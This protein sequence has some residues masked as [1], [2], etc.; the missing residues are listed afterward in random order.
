MRG[1]IQTTL[2]GVLQ[3]NAGNRLTLDDFIEKTNLETRQIQAGI[4]TIIREGKWP[5]APIIRG[6]VWHIGRN[7]NPALNP[8]PAKE[9][10][11]TE[12]EY[13]EL[14]RKHH[15]NGGR[16]PTPEERVRDYLPTA[17]VRDETERE[18]AARYADEQLLASNRAPHVVPQRP[19]PT[20]QRPT[21]LATQATET[22][23][24]Y[25]W[26][27]NRPDGTVLLRDDLGQW[28]VYKEIEKL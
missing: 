22:D 1:D 15:D 13:T 19:T 12:A 3:A 9:P 21:H 10:P 20:P 16:T 6:R 26:M 25:E 17:V 11:Y 28:H 14:A 8:A 24:V 4:S 2:Y 5:I 27:G 23:R 7:A 18:A